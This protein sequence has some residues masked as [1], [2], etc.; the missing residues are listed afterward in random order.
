MHTVCYCAPAGPDEQRQ[1]GLAVALRAEACAM[2]QCTGLQ[3]WAEGQCIQF[4][5]AGIF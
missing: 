3:A 2:W 1:V 4:T 5:H